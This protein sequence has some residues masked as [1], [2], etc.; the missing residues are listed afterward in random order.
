MRMQ[1]PEDFRTAAD[2]VMTHPQALGHQQH[3]T[4]VGAQD[5]RA[6][7]AV[8]QRFHGIMQDLV[9]GMRRQRPEESS[10][11]AHLL[12]IKDHETGDHRNPYSNIR[13]SVQP[14]RSTYVLHVIGAQ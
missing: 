13:L 3:E 9:D 8:T 14:A 7:T 12:E 10:I 4:A 6:G 2:S 5:V 11:A 1:R